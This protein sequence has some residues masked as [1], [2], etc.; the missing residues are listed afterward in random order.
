MKSHHQSSKMQSGQRFNQSGQ[1]GLAKSV[2]TVNKTQDG[3]FLCIIGALQD[4]LFL[5]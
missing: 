1:F 2:A 4:E 3:F 5:H